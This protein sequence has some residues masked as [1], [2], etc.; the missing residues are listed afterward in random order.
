MSYFSQ[1]RNYNITLS[2]DVKCHFVSNY[3]YRLLLLLRDVLFQ[4]KTGA[5]ISHIPLDLS[6]AV[7]I[8]LFS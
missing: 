7:E 4:M 1:I 8:C 2:D 5:S 6:R 3:I